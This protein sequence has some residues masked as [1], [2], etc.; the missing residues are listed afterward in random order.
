M[1]K[2]RLWVLL[3]CIIVL[4]GCGLGNK[5]S[6]NKDNMDS[7]SD[8]EK[9]AYMKGGIVEGQY[10]NYFFDL[11]LALP[12]SWVIL[13]EAEMTRLMQTGEDI[14]SESDTTF[15]LTDLEILNLLGVFKYPFDKV[16]AMNPNLYITAERLDE[17]K[18]IE[19]NEAYLEKARASIEHLGET[20]VFEETMETVN[21]QEKLFT[22]SQ[23]TI[24]LGYMVIYQVH[25]VTLIR[26]YALSIIATYMEQEDFETI[27]IILGLGQ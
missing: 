16:V 8:E 13:S 20:I 26:G 2:Q 4:S 11:E 3:M 27:E 21:I 10:E 24:D 15:D 6:E 17:M 9:V 22:R 1:I 19:S 14:A 25:Y 18:N 12:E 23:A 7:M 5:Q